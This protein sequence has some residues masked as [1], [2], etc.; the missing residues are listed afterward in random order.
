V[1]W[2]R[3]QGQSSA[4][5]F[6][7][8][9]LKKGR[10]VHAYLFAGPDGV[11]KGLCAHV[12]AQALNC[13]RQDGDACGECPSCRAME[14]ASHPDVHIFVP[15]GVKGGIVIGQIRQVDHLSWLAPQ[16][17]GWKVIIIDGAETMD[18][19]PANAFLKTLEEPPPRTMFVLLSAHPDRI[20]TTVRSRC[21]VVR[22]HT[23][24]IDLMVPFLKERAGIGKEESQALH[25]ATGGR[26]GAALRM[27]ED[28]FIATRQRVLRDLSSGGFASAQE[29][30]DAV[31][32]WLDDLDEKH[33]RR[34]AAVEKQ[35]PPGLE[36]DG[37][38]DQE[39][40]E[41]AYLAAEKRAD[42]DRLLAI[43]LSWFRDL[44]LLQANGPRKL[45]INQDYLPAL[46]S[47]A[48]GL[49]SREVRDALAR[50]ERGRQ[51]VHLGGVGRFTYQLTL[52]NLFLQLGF[53]KPG[54]R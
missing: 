49:S 39:E 47:S 27:A 24:P 15:R 5:E 14:R 12:L 53:W 7:R 51:A 54:S 10:T 26:P 44:E 13:R 32:A 19:A 43:I 30:M 25:C 50:V 38:K 29:L 28:K 46:E 11:G 37:L 48:R 31:A 18:D 16:M 9:S 20:M 45:A 8:Q 6:L 21:Q 4:V 41:E 42:F 40:K 34:A 2:D 23:W 35:R 52:E 1:I 3:V 33:H 22:F 36:P 17:D